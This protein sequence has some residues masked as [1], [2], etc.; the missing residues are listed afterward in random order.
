MATTKFTRH[1]NPNGSEGGLVARTARVAASAWIDPEAQVLEFGAVADR[2]RL[3]G[4]VRVA[5]R[6]VVGGHALVR[7]R[8]QVLGHAKVVDHSV[9]VASAAFPNCEYFCRE[10]VVASQVGYQFGRGGE[11]RFH[12]TAGYSAAGLLLLAVQYF[13][14]NVEEWERVLSKASPPKTVPEH[15]HCRREALLDLVS[16]VRRSGP[17]PL[18]PLG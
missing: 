10:M 5:E 14:L 9:V 3:E 1:L 6:G 16:F 18:F 15:L 4:P 17:R 2:A 11:A 8:V 7:G 13:V 12:W